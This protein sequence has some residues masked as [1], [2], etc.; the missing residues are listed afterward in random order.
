[1]T[2]LRKKLHTYIT[3]FNKNDEE[4]YRQLIPND[5]AEEFLTANIPLLEC[6]DKAIEQTYYFRWWT[7][8]KHWKETEVGHIV[9]EFLPPVRW[10]GPYNSIVC[11]ACFHIREGRW[12][13]DDGQWLK[14][15]ITFW[16]EG[17]GQ[18]LAY[19]SWLVWA[20]W[21]Y[22]TIKNDFSY[23]V[24]QLPRLVEFFEERA[25]IHRRSCGLY[26]SNDNRDGME[27][28]ISG[29]GLRPTMNSYVYG[30]A[31]TI[32]KIA[33]LAGDK[34]LQTRFE[35]IA[36]ELKRQMDTL[37]WYKDFY[38][39]LPLGVDDDPMLESRPPVDSAHDVQEQVGYIPWYFGIPG[40][41]KSGCFRQL[42][43]DQAF[44]APWGITTAEQR[45]PRFLEPHT[46]ECLWNGYVWPFATSQ[47]LVAAANLLHA[48]GTA[49]TKDDYYSLL[50][51]YAYCHRIT[52]DDGTI[53]PFIDEVMH[54]YT[55]VWSAREQLKNTGWLE[56]KGGYERG[57]DYNHSLFC[58]LV[59][60]GLLGIDLK[61]G[62]ITVK[63][64]IP[65]SWD[66]FRVEN[67][68]LGGREYA[69]YYDRVGSRYGKGP[70]LHI[71][72]E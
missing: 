39:V 11:P 40:P 41:D 16:L 26:W 60:S 65:D 67:L 6:P 20:V 68:W 70:G 3:A 44:R 27:Y 69:I 45:H 61:N 21:E 63:P 58:D 33:A 14:E 5:R 64:L 59:L 66:Y 47:T 48:G 38:R 54:P 31:V 55:G 42:L 18:R 34:A 50:R 15:Y 1:M 2:D 10:A 62:Q 22:C 37:L 56:K 9:T 32:A 24:E 4:C 30:D 71:C 57:K 17:R 36:S 53:V 13:K 8:R 51:Q 23:A 28:S 52:R 46:H 49:L 43:D 12:L 72:S 35:A 25:T 7:Y 19:S 29:P